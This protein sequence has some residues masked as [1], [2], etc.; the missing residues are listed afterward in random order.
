MSEVVQTYLFSLRT[1]R[2]SSPTSINRILYTQ[3]CARA[4]VCI[5]LGTRNTLLS[6]TLPYKS[7]LKRTWEN[8]VR[9][10]TK[11]KFISVHHIQGRIPAVKQCRNTLYT[12]VGRSV[13]AKAPFNYSW[14]ETPLA[15]AGRFFF[16][17]LKYITRM[18]VGTKSRRVQWPSLSLHY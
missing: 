2:D 3:V 5:Q 8:P 15:A 9:T 7:F 6:V 11:K 12:L 14:R 1:E 17:S 13:D 10:M 18:H 16:K 4:C